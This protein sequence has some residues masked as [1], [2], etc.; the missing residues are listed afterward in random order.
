MGN[1]DSDLLKNDL[2]CNQS[3]WWENPGLYFLLALPCSIHSLSTPLLF[4]ESDVLCKASFIN[5][6]VY[7]DKLFIWEELPL[8]PGVRIVCSP[9]NE[10]S[11]AKS[12]L[13]NHLYD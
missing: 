8:K 2:S 13:E 10:C 12:Y 7:Q 5:C 6:P 3:E 1:Q 11:K 4:Y 9:P